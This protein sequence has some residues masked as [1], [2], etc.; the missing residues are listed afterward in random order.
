MRPEESTSVGTDDYYYNIRSDLGVYMRSTNFHQ[1]NDIKVYSL[2]QACQWG[3]HYLATGLDYFYRRVTNW[4]RFCGVQSSSQLSRRKPL[5]RC[6]WSLLTS[7]YMASSVCGQDESNPALWLATRAGKMGLSCPLGTTR[8][9]PQEKFPRKPYN[10]SSIDQACSVKM[11]GYWPRSLFCETMANIQPSWSHAWS[12]THT[13]LLTGACTEKCSTWTLMRAPLNI[14]STMR[15]RMGSIF[16]GLTGHVY[17]LRQ[18]D[19]W[20]VTYHKST[21]N[22]LENAT[23]M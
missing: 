22:T 5:L 1:G 13:Y 18:V 15:S 16:W 20:G 7:Y 3:D 2:S 12:I 10:K 9:V 19:K 8:R 11:V 23:T 17:C 21:L 14:A 4:Q 6:I